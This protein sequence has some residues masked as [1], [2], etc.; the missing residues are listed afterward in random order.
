MQQQS[1]SVC[2]LIKRPPQRVQDNLQFSLGR[3]RIHPFA[4]ALPLPLPW[5]LSASTCMGLD[6]AGILMSRHDTVSSLANRYVERRFE[7]NSRC[8][9]NARRR[10]ASDN[11]SFVR[12]QYRLYN[13]SQLSIAVRTCSRLCCFGFKTRLN[14]RRFEFALEDQFSLQNLLQASVPGHWVTS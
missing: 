12:M 5:A 11:T 2:G 8:D 7:R 14:N 4:P 6:P 13:R 3:T 10:T 1:H 9:C